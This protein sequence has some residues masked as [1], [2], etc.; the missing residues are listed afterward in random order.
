MSREVLVFPIFVKLTGRPVVLVGGGKVAASKLDGLL[1]VG[2][3][4]T[5]VAPEIR[6]EIERP[7]VTLRR[8]GFEASDLDGAWFAV[9]AATPAVNR[10]VA[11]AAEERRV[12]V[13]AVDDPP[14][15]S[16]YAGGVLRRGRLTVAIST[17]GEAPALAGLIREGLEEL[18]PQEMEAW[19][20]E[21]SEQTQVL[22][23]NGVPMPER[24]PLLLAALNRLYQRRGVDPLYEESRI[25]ETPR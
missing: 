7:D 6:A 1:R 10:R 14:S 9:A 24:R 5:V 12:F 19:L 13:N 2:A 4:V 25:G 22:R 18:I 21:A 11:S 17:N 23:Q 3:R 8:R 15:A 20:R 16:A